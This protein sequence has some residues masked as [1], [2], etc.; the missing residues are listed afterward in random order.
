MSFIYRIAI[1]INRK[2]PYIDW[3]NGFDD[4][5]PKMTAELGRRDAIYLV[6]VAEH[7]PTLEEVLSE[8]W[9]HLFEEELESWMAR[10]EDWPANRTR[11]MFDRWFDATLTDSVIDLAPDEPLTEDDVDAEDF[12]LA[13]RTCAWC[14]REFDDE[15]KP[16]AEGF[17]IERRELLEHREGRVLTLLAQKDRVVTGIVTARESDAAKRGDD[18]VFRVCNR[19]CA[20][21][22]R[23]LVPPALREL[24]ERLA[25]ES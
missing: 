23:K 11:E 19:E 21:P 1:T 6:P 16:R 7:E 3:A 25:R 5:G 14:G 20:Q 22:I 12:E 4:D 2:Q 10:E 13:V 9:E 17:P 15:E 18:L 24:I 8:W